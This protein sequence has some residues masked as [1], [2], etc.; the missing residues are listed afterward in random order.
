M[1]FKDRLTLLLSQSGLTPQEFCDKLSIQRSSLSHLLAG[2]NKPGFDFL[3]SFAR[4]FPQISLRWLIAGIGDMVI[5]THDRNEIKEET[6]S[7]QEC[8]EKEQIDNGNKKIVKV[9]LLYS[10]G[11]FSEYGTVK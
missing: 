10:D 8:T 6:G 9:L 5:Q 2:R 7:V 4:A 11:S 3:D 1:E